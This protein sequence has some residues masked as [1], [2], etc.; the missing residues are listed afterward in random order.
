[1]K[2]SPMSRT[3]LTTN[4]GSS[5][6]GAE[7]A[8]DDNTKQ[9]NHHHNNNHDHH[10]LHCTLRCIRSTSLLLVFLCFSAFYFQFA[11]I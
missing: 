6:G 8:K 3:V 2:A 11:D 9:N 4:T 7:N 10:H 5:R 1:M